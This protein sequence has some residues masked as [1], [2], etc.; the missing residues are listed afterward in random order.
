MSGLAGRIIRSFAF[1]R[2]ETTEVV[3][4]PRLLATLV[5]GPFALLIAF[6]LGLSEQLPTFSALFV[7]PEGSTVGDT[8]EDYAEELASYVEYRGV[9]SSREE[10]IE[11]LL[12]GEVDVVAVLPEDPFSSIRDDHRAVIEV[13]HTS[14]DPIVAAAIEGAA[15]L[16]AD[17]INRQILAT[18]VAEGQSASDLLQTVLPPAEAGVA[19]VR[20]LLESDRREDAEEAIEDLSDVLSDV[21][22][23]VGDTLSLIEGVE[24][25]ATTDSGTP[26]AR[27]LRRAIERLTEPSPEATIDERL[28]QIAVVEQSL[29][30]VRTNLETLRDVRPEVLIRPF[31]ASTQGV[32]N[33]VRSAL[34]FYVPSILMLLLQ[35][36]GITFSALSLVRERQLGTVELFSVAPVSSGEILLGKCVAY[37][38]LG[39]VVAALLIGA[40]R[41]LLDIPYSGTAVELG[42]VT[43]VVLLASI[44]IGFL[45]SLGSTSD[46]QAVQL[47]ML[48]L[49]ASFFF[50]GFFLPLDRLGQPAGI[51]GSVLPATHGISVA[52]EVMLRGNAVPVGDIGQL[53]AIA[54]VTLG[55][56]WR[57]LRRHLRGS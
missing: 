16:A 9:V 44:G 25:A 40:V 49:L 41:L 38:A 8:V 33:D 55:L 45:I 17:E 47:S 39:G 26:T 37:L 27:S 28:E 43:L 35:H 15:R 1:V 21:E 32:D 19:E 48:T 20:R 54:A 3:H 11:R 4:Q 10:A 12:R 23:D 30:A 31:R 42:A 34:G 5:L 51:V 57:G 46:S 2:K 56:T 24:R 36:L 13:Y 50:S 52:R 14:L 29:V 18:I 22:D 6:G 7:A 53:L